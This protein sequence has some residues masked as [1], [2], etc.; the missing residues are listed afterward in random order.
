MLLTAT[1]PTFAQAPALPVTVGAGLQSSMVVDSPD[2]GDTTTQF[3][4]PSARLYVNGPVTDKIKF[5][6][7]TEYKPST[8]E[9]GVL[10]AVAQKQVVEHPPPSNGQ[11]IVLG[12]EESLFCELYTNRYFKTNMEDMKR[13]INETNTWIIHNRKATLNDFYNELGIPATE[14]S[15]RLGRDTGELMDLTF[16]A[17]LTEDGTKP[18]IA[19]RYTPEP[20]PLR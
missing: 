11:V 10:D 7:N 1:S 19:F 2:D 15:G 17:T 6:F 16:H 3:L 13:A 14:V 12:R 5:M 4:I 18:C 9:I 8:S 20:Q